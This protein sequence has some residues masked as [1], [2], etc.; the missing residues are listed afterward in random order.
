MILTPRNLDYLCVDI[1]SRNFYVL[2]EIVKCV[3]R[4]RVVQVE[5]NSRVPF[6]LA[7]SFPRN[8]TEVWKE[9]TPFYGA[10]LQADENP[11]ENHRR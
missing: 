4:P 2:A 11:F 7:L 3:Y 10:S 1:D 5:Y 9:G 6:H 8:S